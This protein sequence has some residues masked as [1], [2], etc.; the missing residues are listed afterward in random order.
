MLAGA[1][2]LW[3]EKQDYY[4]LRVMRLAE[5]EAAFNSEMQNQPI[6]PGDCLFPA[7]WFRY[8]EPYE[9]DFRQRQFQFYGYC[10]PSL[11]RSA[12]SDYSAII[13]LA[14][15]TES[16][17]SY[18]WDADIQRRHPDKIIQDILDKERLLRRE[19]GRGYTL[20]G[21]ETNQFQWFLKE[22]LAQESA[23]Q[24]LYLPIQGIRATEDKTMRIESL[25]PDVKNGYLR[26]RRDQAL[27]LR[28]LEE[29]PLGAYDD[30]PDA[31]EGAR[32]LARR[33]SRPARITGLRI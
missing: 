17:L 8:Y 14:A 33:H 24:G 18:I 22:Q 2:V 5:G 6:N 20:F 7:Q 10:D 31:L 13:T 28:Q 3:P 26:F 19:T 15:D 9:T 29:F 1:K 27:L 25:Q 12:S 23:R 32:T 30:G 21:A 4:S 11:G 16:G